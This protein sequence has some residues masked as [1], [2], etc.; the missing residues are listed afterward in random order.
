MNGAKAWPWRQRGKTL[1]VEDSHGTVILTARSNA[2]QPHTP[3]PK[4]D[5]DVTREEA[6]QTA[7]LAAQAP[8]LLH[9]LKRLVEVAREVESDGVGLDTERGRQRFASYCEMAENA[10]AQAETGNNKGA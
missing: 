1:S 3:R 2:N 4:G 10:I 5:R 6:L 8:R 9:A 7:H